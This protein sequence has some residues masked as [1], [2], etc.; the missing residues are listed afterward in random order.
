MDFPERSLTVLH[1]PEPLLEFGLAQN[2]AHPKDGLFLYG[3]YLKPRGR[4]SLAF[5]SERPAERRN[6]F[7]TAIIP[8][9]AERRSFSMIV[10]QTFGQQVT[11]HKWILISDLKRQ[12]LC[13]SR[14]CAAKTKCLKSSKS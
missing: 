12:T 7:E 3:P 10:T 4:M 9:C 11:C 1:L 13:S 14:C 6:F 2:T 5:G 8:S